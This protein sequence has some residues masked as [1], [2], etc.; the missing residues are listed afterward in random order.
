LIKDLPDFIDVS[1]DTLEIG[2]SAKVGH[3]QVS[4]F[5]LLDSP[6]NA[7]VSVNTTRALMQA[8]A[9]ANKK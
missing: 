4:G 5:D 7:I 3:L 9:E 8:A 2:Q 1:I 6:A